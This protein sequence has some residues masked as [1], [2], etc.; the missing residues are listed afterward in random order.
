MHWW[1]G[2]PFT[3]HVSDHGSEVKSFSC[4]RLFSF[5]QRLRQLFWWFRKTVSYW[6]TRI[7]ISIS[8]LF[9][10]WGEIWPT[11]VNVYHLAGWRLPPKSLTSLFFV[12][13][14]GVPEP[15]GMW[16]LSS[17]TRDQTCG[18]CSGSTE[19][20]NHWTTR[21]VPLSPSLFSKKQ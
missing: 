10:S 14:A 12:E 2:W 6:I 3:F 20:L 1:R 18:P 16:F 15:H 21:E 8:F 9:C 13:G 17:M 19:S 4:V 11:H 7:V 5:H